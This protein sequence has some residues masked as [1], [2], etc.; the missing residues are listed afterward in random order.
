MPSYPQRIL[1]GLTSR[2]SHSLYYLLIVSELLMDNKAASILMLRCDPLIFFTEVKHGGLGK[3][4][5]R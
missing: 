5:H 1:Q 4:A 3:F 2:D